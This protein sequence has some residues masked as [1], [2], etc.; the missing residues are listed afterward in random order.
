M[1]NNLNAR[2][3]TLGAFQEL[4]SQAGWQL[5]EV[6]ANAGGNS[7]YPTLVAEPMFESQPE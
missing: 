1:L 3:R 6:R 7:W 4:F 5:V 2:E